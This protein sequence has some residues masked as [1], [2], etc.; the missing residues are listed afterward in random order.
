VEDQNNLQAKAVMKALF[1]EVLEIEGVKGAM[2]FSQN[3]DFVYKE[4]LGQTPIAIENKDFWAT[5]FTYFQGVKEFEIVFEESMLYI[6]ETS[7]GYLLISMESPARIAL[8][9]LNCDLL[10]ASLEEKKSPKGR[11]G[12]FRKKK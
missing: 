9:R 2:L 5:T 4:F 8:V 3:G 12:F 11:W 7:L 6:K 1:R 10:A